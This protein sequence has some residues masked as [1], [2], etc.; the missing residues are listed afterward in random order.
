MGTALCLATCGEL[1]RLG[2]EGQASSHRSPSSHGTT[3]A[4]LL[5]SVHSNILKRRQSWPKLG[6][7]PTAEVAECRDQV[8]TWVRG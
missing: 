7:C 6:G 1:E 3:G 4:G 5:I 8:G 2:S